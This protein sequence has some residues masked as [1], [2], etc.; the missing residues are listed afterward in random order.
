V[1]QRRSHN[2]DILLFVG[3]KR[4]MAE[5]SAMIITKKSKEV[6]EISSEDNT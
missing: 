4:N 1:L 2:I 5:E 6:V 3:Y